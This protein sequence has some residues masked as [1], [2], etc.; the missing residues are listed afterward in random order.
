MS[1]HD[2]LDYCTYGLQAV[3][4]AQFV[5]VDYSLG[6]KSQ[7]AESIKNDVVISQHI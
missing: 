4:D 2:L 6:K 5:R 1:D 3:N 7:P